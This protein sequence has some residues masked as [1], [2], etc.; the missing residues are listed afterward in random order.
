MFLCYFQ[1]VFEYGELET[2]LSNGGKHSFSCTKYHFLMFIFEYLKCTRYGVYRK[3]NKNII[4]PTSQGILA[5]H[6]R[7]STI[8]FCKSCEVMTMYMVVSFTT[9]LNEKKKIKKGMVIYIYIK[10]QSRLQ[11]STSSLLHCHFQ[12]L[13]FVEANWDAQEGQGNTT[14][15]NKT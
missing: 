7:H 2:L 5:V 4:E 6:Q 3:Y 14:K 9:V 1:S 11:H 8:K 15:P 13:L 12:D 10:I